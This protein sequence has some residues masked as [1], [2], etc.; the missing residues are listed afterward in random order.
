MLDKPVEAVIRNDD[1]RLLGVDG[2][3]GKVLRCSARSSMRAV[4]VAEATY[5]G[6]AEMAL[7]DGLEE[8]GFTD[9]SKPDLASTVNVRT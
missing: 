5:C 3:I 9:V 1:A 4:D 2:G 6:V 8:G 7:R